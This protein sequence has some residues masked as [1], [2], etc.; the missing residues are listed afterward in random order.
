L[1]RD[2]DSGRW[3]NFGAYAA[4]YSF[5]ACANTDDST[6]YSPNPYKYVFADFNDDDS[7]NCDP[8]DLLLAGAGT[9]SAACLSARTI[10]PALGTND[11]RTPDCTGSPNDLVYRSN[12]RQAGTA[13]VNCGPGEILDSDDKRCTWNWN[14]KPTTAHDTGFGSDPEDFFQ[15]SESF[16][17]L[18]WD[19]VTKTHI[20]RNLA[21]NGNT[22]ALE[23][24]LQD[25]DIHLA[26][27]DH[28]GNNVCTAGDTLTFDVPSK[29][30]GGSSDVVLGGCSTVNFFDNGGSSDWNDEVYVEYKATLSCASSDVDDRDNFPDCYQG[31]EIHFSVAYTVDD[32]V[33]SSRLQRL[34]P[35]RTVAKISFP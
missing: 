27:K 13:V 25:V 22:A 31:D 7:A 14:F 4:F 5:I 3:P 35:W 8:Q 32:T 10:V 30:L 33:N 28:E 1:Q 29:Y 20:A 23:S 12:I 19:A 16:D 21:H 18:V 9:E 2:G 17:F 24:P 11:Y 15:R 6:L 34:D 26:F